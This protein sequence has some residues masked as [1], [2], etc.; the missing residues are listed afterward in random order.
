MKKRR[1]VII[2][3]KLQLRTTFIIIATVYLFITF[4][5]A[6]VATNAIINN[7]NLLTV[8]ENQKKTISTQHDV[9]Q[10]IDIFTKE[11]NWKTLRLSKNM[12]SQ[13]IK[14]NIATLN[15]NINTVD[16]LTNNTRLLLYVIIIIVIIQGIVMVYVLL[17]ITHRISGPIY[18]ISQYIKDITQLKYPAI[19]PLRAN[20]EF[21]EF[22]ELVVKMADSLKKAKK[23]K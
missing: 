4:V 11:K 12:I 13:D 21:K 17:N 7:S 9:L 18:H 14:A 3:K 20:D 10:A 16:K 8:I 5:I 19:R 2:N 6:A 23:I 1:T 22:H 15:N